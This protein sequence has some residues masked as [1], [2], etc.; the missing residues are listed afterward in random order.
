MRSDRP[1]S[2]VGQFILWTLRRRAARIEQPFVLWSPRLACLPPNSWDHSPLLCR[3]LFLVQER[4]NYGLRGLLTQK[5][6]CIS[7]YALISKRCQVLVTLHTSQQFVVQRAGGMMVGLSLPLSTP[8]FYNVSRRSSLSLPRCPHATRSSRAA[9]FRSGTRDKIAT[10]SALRRKQGR[11]EGRKEGVGAD[12]GGRKA[13]RAMEQR[14]GGG[15]AETREVYCLSF[16]AVVAPE[17][18]SA[19]SFYPRF[20]LFCAAVFVRRPGR[21][22]AAGPVS[23]IVFGFWF[24]G[25]L[26]V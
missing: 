13:G 3:S 24:A 25:S 7:E 17:A 16:A 9:I 18:G 26:F 12:K 11:K 23:A 8:G 15:R 2:R 1:S 19:G 5:A 22:A 14:G 6:G 20:R 4:P 10:D 21:A